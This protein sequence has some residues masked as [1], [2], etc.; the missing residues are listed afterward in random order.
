MTEEEKV[1]LAKL[2]YRHTNDT[3]YRYHWLPSTG[4]INDWF[5]SYVELSRLIRAYFGNTAEDSYDVDT[6]PLK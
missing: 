1:R 3:E 6:D 2:I 5:I 4:L